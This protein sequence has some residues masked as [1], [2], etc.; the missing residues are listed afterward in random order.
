MTLPLKWVNTFKYLG[1]VIDRKLKWGDQINHSTSKVTKI[2]NL[3]RRNLNNC[4]V[5]VKKRVYLT[6]F[7]PHQ[8]AVPVWSPHQKDITTLEK[9]RKE[10][11]GGFVLSGTGLPTNGANHMKIAARNSTAYEKWV[12][13]AVYT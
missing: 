13:K 5:T 8:F 10:Q 9:Y 11:Q 3:P 2:L 6:L 12:S 1:V 4:S 7:R